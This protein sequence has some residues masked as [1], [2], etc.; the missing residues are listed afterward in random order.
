MFLWTLIGHDASEGEVLS[1]VSP[2]LAGVLRAA[3]PPLQ[4]GRAFVCR[5][6]EVVPRLSVLHL[7]AVHV[8]TGRE[9]HGRRDNAGGVYWAARH[10]S[11]DP[12]LVYHP[13][14]AQTRSVAAG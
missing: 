9:W 14:D 12:G 10:V 1:G 6:V 8:P 3:E 11:A 2:E 7:G 5:V 13:A 4:D